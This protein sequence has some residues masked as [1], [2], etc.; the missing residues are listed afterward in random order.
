MSAE[1]RDDA[2]RSASRVLGGGLLAAGA[3]AV[4][5]L[6]PLAFPT[7]PS[8]AAQGLLA[9]SGVVVLVGLILF[10]TG[11]RAPRQSSAMDVSRR[12][13]PV[14]VGQGWIEIRVRNDAGGQFVVSANT[15]NGADQ[16]A[17]DITLGG[18][19]KPRRSDTVELILEVDGQAFELDVEDTGGQTFGFHALLWR[20]VELLRQIVVA[21]RSGRELSVAVPDAGLRATFTTAGAYDALQ[22]IETLGQVEN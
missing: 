16:I 14:G 20:E 3:A 7:M 21:V 1:S 6:V 18:A 11:W 15:G 2:H 13:T 8:W 10:W 4:P 17:F 9:V 19:R 22:E 5:L 12:W